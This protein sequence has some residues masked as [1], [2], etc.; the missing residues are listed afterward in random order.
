MIVSATVDPR[1][2]PPSFWSDLQS[3]AVPAGIPVTLSVQISSNPT[4]TI[5]WYRNG[6]Q[7]QSG[8]S[9]QLVLGPFSAAQAGNYQVILS[10]PAG[11]VEGD[12]VDVTLAEAGAAFTFMDWAEV[13]GGAQPW[14]FFNPSADGYGLGAPNILC[15]A[16]GAAPGARATR[17]QPSSAVENGKLSMRFRMPR[18][19]TGVIIHAE[20]SSDLINWTREGVELV[21]E[22]QNDE[23]ETWLARPISAANAR[24]FLR[25]SAE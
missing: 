14:M 6:L 20:M 19:V 21:K 4:T 18:Y 9:S 17:L 15:Y 7:V 16:F 25:L 23:D 3:K 24:V 5:S 8:P 10:N 13:Q 1:T 2:I 11:R 22:S 12:A